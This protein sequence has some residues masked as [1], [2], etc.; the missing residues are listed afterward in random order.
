MVSEDVYKNK[1]LKKILSLITLL[2]KC[3]GFNQNHSYKEPGKP[4][5]EIEKTIDINTKMTQILESPDKDFKVAII[6]ML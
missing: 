4:Q 1:D 3:P 6:K 2:P 5:L